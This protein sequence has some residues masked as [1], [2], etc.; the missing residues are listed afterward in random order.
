MAFLQH[1]AA[2][3][4]AFGNIFWAKRKQFE[5]S[6]GMRCKAPE[7]S[8]YPKIKWKEDISSRVSSFL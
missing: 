8:I 5:K 4:C 6:S 2:Q 3:A 7:G 1:S